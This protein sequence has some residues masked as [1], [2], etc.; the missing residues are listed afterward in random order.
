MPVQ[1]YECRKCG[2]RIEEIEPMGAPAVERACSREMPLDDGDK[3]RVCDGMMRR[4]IGS[5]TFKFT[6][7]PP[8]YQ[9]KVT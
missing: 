2:Y 7:P 5:M 6:V 8:T 3:Y 9:K 1:I 4:V